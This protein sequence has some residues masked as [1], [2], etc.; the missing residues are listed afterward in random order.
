MGM[1]YL[2]IHFCGVCFAVET[3]LFT[4]YVNPDFGSLLSTLLLS[5]LLVTPTY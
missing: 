4:Y 5:P 2:P 1:G 3:G